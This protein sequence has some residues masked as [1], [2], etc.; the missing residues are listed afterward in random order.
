MLGQR[1]VLMPT[2][3]GPYS[4][5]RSRTTSPNSDSSTKTDL[6]ADSW[7][8]PGG[9]PKRL[10][11]RCVMSVRLIRSPPSSARTA[12]A[13]GDSASTRPSFMS[14]THSPS[15]TYSSVTLWRSIHMASSE[16]LTNQ[17]LEV[18][19]LGV[20]DASKAAGSVKEVCDAVERSAERREI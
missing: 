10:T 4:P 9:A 14:T 20:R 16:H 12:L 2:R 15:S 5:T 7:P 3:D 6:V 13:S 18:H 1:L 17:R 19:S 8:V 11:M